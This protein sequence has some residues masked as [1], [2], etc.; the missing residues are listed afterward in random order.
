MDLGESIR[1]SLRTIRGHKL[2]SALTTLGIVIGI[3]AVITFVTLGASLKTEVVGQFGDTQANRVYLIATPD[4][5]GGPPASAAQPVF[6]EQDITNLEQLEGV[7]TVIPRG[8]IPI[9][10]I[11]HRNDTI[12]RDQVTA[13][14]PALFADAEFESGGS[15]TESRPG[16]VINRPAAQL[17]AE[18]LSVGDEVTLTRRTGEPINVTVVGI[19]GEDAA[20]NPLAG[21]ATQ[22]RFYLSTEYYDT[23]VESPSLGVTQRVYPQVTVAAENPAETDAVKQ[24]VRQYLDASDA[25]QLAPDSYD[26]T[27]RTNEDIVD[28]VKT[29]VNRLTQFVTGIAVIALIVG[30]IGIANI[31]LV[32]V[33]ERTKEIGIMKAVGAQNRDVLQLFLV[34]AILLGALGAV[35]GTPLGIA[36][37]YAAVWYAELPLTL[38]WEW[39]VVAVV[40]GVLVGVLA[41]LYPAWSATRV[42]PVD[43]LRYE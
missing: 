26:V 41:G 23:V 24:R 6:T 1:M 25:S 39:F 10:S 31:M 3:A 18:N 22:P 16:M 15:F 19:L 20:L 4:E 35:L 40:I 28:R 5:D 29:V 37:G 21:F 9:S 14:T 12:A 43:A 8:T 36:G 30:A 32:S 2:R 38:A 11:N 33:R 7:S 13:T 42:D 27:A 17:F 34:E